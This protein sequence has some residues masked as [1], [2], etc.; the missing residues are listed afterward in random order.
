MSGAV[1]YRAVDVFD[2][3]KRLDELK[4]QAELQM[5]SID[6]LLVPTAA[7]HYTIAGACPNLAD[8]LSVTRKASRGEVVGGVLGGVPPMNS[9]FDSQPSAVEARSRTSALTRCISKACQERL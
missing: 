1:G 3:F 2:A 8:R 5:E 6:V 4:C 7:H 9:T